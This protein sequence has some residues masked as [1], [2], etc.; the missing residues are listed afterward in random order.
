VTLC[1][2]TAQQKHCVIYRETSDSHPK[3]VGKLYDQ[4]QDT[5]VQFGN[6]LGSTYSVE[7]YVDRLPSIHSMLQ[8]YHI[9]S[10]VAFFLARP[11]FTHA[12]NQ[13]YEMLRKNDTSLK[14]MSSAQ[15]QEKYIEASNFVM[16]PVIESVRPLHPNKVWEDISPQFLVTFWSLSMFDLQTPSESY[17]R[18][19]NKLKQQISSLTSAENGN[20][21]SSKTKKELDRI[22]IFI[23]K[24]QE[25]KKKQQEHVEKIMAR[26]NEE[27]DSW[28]PA[29]TTKG[30]TKNETIPQFLQLCLFPRCTFT[31]LDA[32]YCAKFVNLIHNLKTPN[33]ST[34]LCFDRVIM[35]DS[36]FIQFINLLFK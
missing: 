24:L 29:R 9:H 4:C 35:L 32:L 17:Q 11:M 2:L 30:A 36:N 34:L 15:K 7:E 8:E 27:K 1:L 22:Q 26:L 33:F 23:D 19:I 21:S 28:F 16:N 3:L 13:K 6:F 18:E 10:D 20:V 12:I 14:K 25:E 31:A 5:L